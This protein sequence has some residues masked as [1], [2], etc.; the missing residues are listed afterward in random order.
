MTSPKLVALKNGKF[1]ET[2]TAG[3]DTDVSNQ[4]DPTPCENFCCCLQTNCVTDEQA[5]NDGATPAYI[6]AQGGYHQCIDVLA[7]LR[8]DLSI[9]NKDE[10]TPLHQANTLRVELE[11]KGKLIK[12]IF[13]RLL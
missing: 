7:S 5:A 2:R 10:V 12:K 1:F 8:A 6:A 3:S 4:R 11:V 13:A 9:G